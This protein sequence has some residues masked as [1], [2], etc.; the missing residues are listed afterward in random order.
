MITYSNESKIG[1]LGVSSKTLETQGA[2]SD[3]TVQEMA[4]GVRERLKSNI[5]LS[6]SGIAGPEGGTMKKPVGTVYIGLAADDKV[7]SG[8][9]RFQGMREEIKL[10]TAMMALDWVRRYLHEDPFLSGI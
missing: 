6:V 10:N 8:K 5:G 4:R 3:P 9:Y 2:V 1:L 7:L